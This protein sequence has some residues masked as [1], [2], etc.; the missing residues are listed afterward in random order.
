MQQQG[1][2]SVE[3]I[4]DSIKKVIARDNREGMILERRRRSAPG[5]T[6]ESASPSDE[7]ETDEVLE[8]AEEIAL[9]DAS[10]TSG[11]DGESAD[12]DTDALT[13]GV[14]EQ[15]HVDVVARSAYRVAQ[16]QGRVRDL[17]AGVRECAG[18]LQVRLGD[19]EQ[20][21]ASDRV[22]ARH[23]LQSVG[24]TAPEALEAISMP[25]AIVCGDEDRDN[26]SPERLA[27]AIPD[28]EHVEVDF[29]PPLA[30]RE[31]DFVVEI[32]DVKVQGEVAK[33]GSGG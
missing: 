8:L 26:G 31:L 16:A 24:D 13:R 4:L 25:T 19:L 6:E 14:L 22:A 20:T 2:P 28:A 27:E 9:D 11:D 17:G 10:A 23:L 5:S 3:E 12:S 30:G 29:N 15:R 21:C 7:R 18:D 1:E 33:P 32:I